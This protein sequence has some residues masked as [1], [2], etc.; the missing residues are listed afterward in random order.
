MKSI[1]LSQIAKHG[2]KSNTVEQR[3][4]DEYIALV[5]LADERVELEKSRLNKA[6]L[7]CLS[8]IAR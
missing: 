5:K 2:I 6:Y 1:K 3:K 8:C 7:K 4:D